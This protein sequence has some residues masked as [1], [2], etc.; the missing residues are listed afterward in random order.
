VQ[1]LI[2]SMC[3]HRVVVEQAGRESAVIRVDGM[4]S[5]F[6][7]GTLKF[8]MSN[9]A[10]RRRLET[11]GGASIKAF[12]CNGDQCKNLRFSHTDFTPTVVEGLSVKNDLLVF[13]I[14]LTGQ[15]ELVVTADT[16]A[17][18]NRSAIVAGRAALTPRQSHVMAYDG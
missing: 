6:A 9:P 18:R 11:A 17:N 3:G 2:G 16:C 1:Q 4:T 13:F 7:Y 5:A 15:H 12:I 14:L 8:G 10:V